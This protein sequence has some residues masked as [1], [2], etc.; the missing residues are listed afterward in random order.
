MQITQTTIHFPNIRLQARDAHKLRG[1][2]GNLF[3]EHSPLLHNHYQ[4]G[5]SRYAYPLVQYKVIE[6]VP[7]LLGLQEGANLLAAL[8]L[9][10]RG[11]D[12][13]GEQ[14]PVLAKNIQ[15]KVYDLE[16][17][18]QLYNYSFKTYWMALNQDNHKKYILL[19]PTQ[20]PWFLNHLLQ[21]NILSFYK[22]V[23]FRT[24]E[25]ILV[26]SDLEERVSQFKNKPM[27]VFSGR[28]TTNAFLP[29]L[30][31]VGKSVSRGFGAVSLKP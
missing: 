21:N 24:S 23:S 20:K 17:N 29:E 27:I 4:D 28:F 31:G 13:E 16:V 3:Q 5:T 15:K 9:K 10:I 26:T 2:F 1:Y 12:I 8:F 11:I 22:G 30:V 19:E 25:Q 18:K 6:H 14:I 7:V